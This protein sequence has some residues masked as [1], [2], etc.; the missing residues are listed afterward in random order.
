[1]TQIILDG[2]LLPETS[3]DKYSCAPEDLSVQTT[4]ISGR[5]TIETRGSVWVASYSYD[6]MGE[7]LQRR[8]LRVLRSGKPFL[9][10]VLPDNDDE[11]ITSIFIVTAL[12]RPS[13]AFSRRQGDKEKAFWHRLAFTLR[14]ERPHG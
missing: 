6:Y 5:V 10:S 7:E 2:V 13:M 1:M 12:E 8:A 3:K 9:A 11:L 14:E 4:M